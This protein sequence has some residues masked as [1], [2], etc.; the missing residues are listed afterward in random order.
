M[1]IIKKFG[2]ALLA[3]LLLLSLCACGQAEVSDSLETVTEPAR[4]EILAPEEVDEPP[5]IPE[6][7]GETET[8]EAPPLDEDGTYTSKE[9]VALYIHLYGRLPQN[10][11]TKKDAEKLGWPGGSLEPYAPGMCIGGS[12][13]RN[14]EGLLPEADGRTYTECDID[15]LGAEKRG[16]KRIVFSNDGLIYYTEDHYKTFELL[17]GEETP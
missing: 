12:R 4:Q 14:Y 5:E 3:L 17:Y 1:K 2:A 15:T 10:F 13:F 7:P 8:S 11:I 6:E 9:D 16:A